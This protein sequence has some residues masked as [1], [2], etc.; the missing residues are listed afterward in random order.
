M[1]RYLSDEDV[2]AVACRVVALLGERLTATTWQPPTSATPVAE[3][4]KTTPA[5]LAYTLKQLCEELSVSPETMWRFEARG[6]IKSLPGIRRKIY[7]RAEVERLLAGGKA[8]W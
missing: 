5:R 8:R 1:P 2:E 6:L 4:S 3:A 7:S